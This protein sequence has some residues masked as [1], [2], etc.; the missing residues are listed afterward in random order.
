MSRF[1]RLHI[2]A[3][4]QTEERFVRHTLAEHLGYFQISTD[5][6]AVMTSRDK[7]RGT[8]HR[9]GLISYQKARKD[10]QIWLKEDRHPEAR[11]TT[12]F[13]FYALPSDF[14]G[15]KE[16]EKTADPY[17]KIELLEE[18]FQ[19]DIHDPRF[20]PYIQLHEFEA[21]VLADPG[22]LGNEYFEHDEAIR[23]LQDILQKSDGNPE[24]IN[25]QPETAP[26]KRILRCIPEYDKVSIGADLAGENGIDFLKRQC[27][28]F[29]SWVQSLE[30]LSS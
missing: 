14:P 23:T 12:M 19:E 7:R 2:I 25:D 20:M 27:P 4:G 16:A 17:Q 26:S 1:I 6:R 28:H 9:G 3:E 15:Y 22:K 10:I 8:V 30:Q 29:R 13:D 24:L 21:L 5:V 18:S 11:F